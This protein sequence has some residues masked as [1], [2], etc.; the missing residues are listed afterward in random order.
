[1]NETRDNH[2]QDTT[3]SNIVRDIAKRNRMRSIIHPH[4]QVLTSWSGGSKTDFQ[5]LQAIA[6]DIGY[7]V[8]V[9]G[10]TV[11]F[12]DPRQ[13]LIGAATMNTPVFSFGRGLESVKVVAGSSAP[14]TRSGK[15]KVIYG[16]DYRTNLPFQTVSGNK[17]DPL[18][19]QDD[20]VTTYGDA[21][22]IITSLNKDG[23]DAYTAK[24]VLRG[25]PVV[26]PTSLVRLTGSLTDTQAGSW[27]VT[28]ASHEIRDGQYRVFATGI[29]A[30]KFRLGNDLVTTLHETREVLPA[31]VRDGSNWEAQVMEQVNV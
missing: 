9:D 23:M 15:R 20:I 2:W 30:E 13:I 26:T 27:L 17:D 11:Y 29:R 21:Q 18:R 6:E 25:N 24:M 19:M 28:E 3:R 8:W 16:L 7:Q 1:M 14:G 4:P 5:C 31:V 10:A 12:L 22:A